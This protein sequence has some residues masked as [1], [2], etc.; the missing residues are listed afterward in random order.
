MSILVL[1][2]IIATKQQTISLSVHLQCLTVYSMSSPTLQDSFTEEI[3]NSWRQTDSVAKAWIPLWV[4]GELAADN[5][6]VQRS[7]LQRG[8]LME[9]NEHVAFS[10]SSS[11][12][13]FKQ[14][15]ETHASWPSRL[16]RV[17]S[18]SVGVRGGTR[19]WVSVGADACSLFLSLSLSPPVHLITTRWGGLFFITEGCHIILWWGADSE[20]S[21]ACNSCFGL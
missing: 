5:W 3:S 4:T 1:I 16:Q 15:W 20:A 2:I 7:D 19:G 9:G 14:H 18:G 11:Y 21:R 6:S 10:P 17:Q 12:P 13:H 8:G